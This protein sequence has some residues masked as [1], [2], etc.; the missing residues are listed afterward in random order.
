MFRILA[1][2]P[3]LLRDSSRRQ[4]ACD[5]CARVSSHLLV[6]LVVERSESEGQ[7]SH[8]CLHADLLVGRRHVGLFGEARY[9]VRHVA[10]LHRPDSLLA[11]FVWGSDTRLCKECTVRFV[12]VHVAGRP[13][14]RMS[15]VRYHV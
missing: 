11:V 14:S 13:L 7:G 2:V 3:A 12:F 8:G 10:W 4:C 5:A 1:G 6:R 9:G 15:D